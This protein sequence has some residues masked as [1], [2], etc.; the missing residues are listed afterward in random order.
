MLTDSFN[1][2]QLVLSVHLAAVGLSLTLFSFRLGCQFSAIPWRTRWPS[3]R[4]L[5]H[6]NDTVLLFAGIG[7]CVTAGW[8]PW[9]HGWLGL[10]LALLVTYVL[11]GKLA[12]SDESSIT[13]QRFGAAVALTSVAMMILLAVLKPF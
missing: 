13:G 4:W 9:V 5:P 3:L 12:L 11:S 7:L 6:A 8:R 10:K 2:Y 1:S